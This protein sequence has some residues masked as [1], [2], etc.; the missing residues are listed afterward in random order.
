M[1]RNATN[2]GKGQASVLAKFARRDQDQTNVARSDQTA[3]MVRTRL[4]SLR[5]T[6]GWS[7]DDLAERSHLSASTISR[8][9]T[10]KRALSLDASSLW[11]MRW[12]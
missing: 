11:P 5:R 3:T 10:G 1:G 6:L 2:R 9:E 4:R 12:T 8:I 7:L